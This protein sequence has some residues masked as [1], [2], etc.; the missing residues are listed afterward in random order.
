[1]PKIFRGKRLSPLARTLSLV[2]P[3]VRPNRGLAVGGIVALS[4]APSP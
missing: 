1:M 2:G 3:D 4:F